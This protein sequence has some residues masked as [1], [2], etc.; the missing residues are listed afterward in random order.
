[1]ACIAAKPIVDGLETEYAGK[2]AVVR[3]NVQDPAHRALVQQ[4]RALGTPTFLL[5]DAQGQE[6]LR[7]FGRLDVQAVREQLAAP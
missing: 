2:L 1:M 5:L 6:V 7:S 4:Y 3:L